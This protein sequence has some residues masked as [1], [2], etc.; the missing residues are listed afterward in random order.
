MNFLISL[1]LLMAK[2]ASCC[3]V[4][5][6]ASTDAEWQEAAAYIAMGVMAGALKP[7]VG[8]VYRGLDAAPAAHEEVIGHKEGGGSHGKVV[9]DLSA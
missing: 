3:G 2:E 8:P 5:L 9:I 7:I 4:M 1:Q 6:G